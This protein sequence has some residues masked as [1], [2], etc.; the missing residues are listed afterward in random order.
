MKIK[1]EKPDVILLGGEFL[2]NG[3]TVSSKTTGV[4][5][6]ELNLWDD[7]KPILTAAIREIRATLSGV[8]ILP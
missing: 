1:S 3:F 7:K 4:D 5:Q 8:D 2:A 6:K